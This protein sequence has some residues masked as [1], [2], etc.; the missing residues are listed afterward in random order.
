[1]QKTIKKL[2]KDSI[3]V[4]EHLFTQDTS[5]IEA[6]ASECIKAIQGGSKIIFCG[7][8]GSAA[9]SQHLAAEFVVRF[10]KNRKSW[11]AIAL[12]T[13]TSILTAIGNDFGFK[14]LFSRQIESMGNEGDVL[15]AITTSGKSENI[16]N[17][18][19]AARTK[20]IKTIAFTGEKGK[21]FA[22]FCDL[23]LIAPS[24]DTARVQEIH[25]LVGHIICEIVEEK[26]L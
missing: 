21:S 14:E 26:L 4:K 5:N 8:G 24:S 12:T 13:N 25:S 10:K 22:E 11:P 3:D 17:A 23:A 9:D 18:V 6:I 15:I 20:G 1:M 2:I 16:T 7:N 19:K